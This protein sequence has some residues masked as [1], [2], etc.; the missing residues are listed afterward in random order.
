MRQLETRVEHPIGAHPDLVWS[1]RPGFSNLPETNSAV[2]HQAR[3]GPRH[4]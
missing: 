3:P 1:Y 4:G 2:H